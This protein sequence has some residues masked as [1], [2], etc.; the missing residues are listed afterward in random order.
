MGNRPDGARIKE[1]RMT[2]EEKS[3]I[4]GKK[5][6]FVT[7]SRKLINLIKDRLLT[8]EYEFYIIED[9]KFLKNILS[10]NPDSIC[11]ISPDFQLKREGWHNLIISLNS[12][13][14]YSST[15]IGII[16]DGM[17]QSEL[18]QFQARLTLEAGLILVDDGDDEVF[19]FIIKTLDKFQAKGMRQYVRANCGSDSS[20]GI[21]WTEGNT[22]YKMR[23]LD[24]SSVGIAID[25]P[26]KFH[27]VF[28]GKT[29][30]EH[31]TLILNK[32]EYRLALDIKM[33]K[34]GRNGYIGI[35]MFRMGI[36]KKLLD[37]IRA[38]ISSQLT[39]DLF[40]TIAKRPADR[41]DYNEIAL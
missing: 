1:E 24:I 41:T 23:V 36:P 28:N 22:M 3:K 30:I 13:S 7:Q 32:K 9:Y 34:P 31:C 38:Y 35:A 29:G 8:L 20:S 2:Q 10:E 19:R 27:H 37:T 17:R 21:F 11:F 14:E 18:D 5:V 26:E 25:I 33:I 4:F 39:N 15:K 16:S 40:E 6:F 12:D